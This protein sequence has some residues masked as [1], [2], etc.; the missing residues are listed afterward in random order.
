MLSKLWAW[1]IL[2]LLALVDSFLDM[3]FADNTGLKSFFWNPVA[4]F[5]GMKYAPLAVPV[6]LL[7][8]FIAVKI[9][10]LLEE[11]IEKV[12]HAEE[13]VLTTLV[14]AYGAFNLWLISFYFF[15]FSLLNNRLHLIIILIIIAT[16]Y[17]W[18]AEKRL[19]KDDT[20]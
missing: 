5:T 9:G 13:L 15:G 8:F 1:I 18:W 12:H 7:I 10:T 3:F 4:N 11:K 17:A 14:I 16:A 20:K 19:K 2:V 6:L